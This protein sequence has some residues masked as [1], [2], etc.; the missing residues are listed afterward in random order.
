LALIGIL[1]AFIAL[2]YYLTLVK[3]MYLYES[4]QQDVAAPVSR[5]VWTGSGGSDILRHFA[6]RVRGSG[7]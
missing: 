1:N 7:I 6:G 4:D 2:Y 3:Y 5:G